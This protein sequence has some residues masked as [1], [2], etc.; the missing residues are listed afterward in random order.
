MDVYFLFRSLKW[1]IKL[2]PEVIQL[3]VTFDI[4]AQSL[5]FC[6]SDLA[7]HI[8]L[9]SVVTST[10]ILLFIVILRRASW[11]TINSS[12][13]VE[14]LKA[15]LDQPAV[16]PEAL[17]LAVDGERMPGGC[18][19]R[20]MRFFHQSPSHATCCFW[21]RLLNWVWEESCKNKN[22]GSNSL[23]IRLQYAYAFVYNPK[24]IEMNFIDTDQL[25]D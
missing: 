4:L 24:N 12:D 8:V 19:T 6:L 1:S 7:A 20:T 18:G 21:Y 22:A 15:H 3:V 10:F 16:S 23:L 5:T 11:V 9:K 25:K 13:S 14:L 17:R 2:W